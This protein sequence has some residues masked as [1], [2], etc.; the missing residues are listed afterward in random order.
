MEKKGH[1][2]Q[3]FGTSF[4]MTLVIFIVEF[5]I[6]KEALNGNI[7][8]AAAVGSHLIIS[9]ICIFLLLRGWGGRYTYLIAL[10]VGLMGPFGAGMGLVVLG[11]YVLDTF[12]VDSASNLIKELMPKMEKSKSEALYDR[13]QSGMESPEVDVEVTPL[14]DI[15]KMGTRKQKLVAIEKVLQYYHPEFI[16]ALKMAIVD[17]DNSVR[18][19]AATAISSLEDHF[20]KRFIELEADCLHLPDDPETILRFADHCFEYAKF[21]IFEEGRLKAIREIAIEKYKEYL[22]LRPEDKHIFF[23]LGS[24]YFNNGNYELA[25]ETIESLTKQPETFTQDVYLKLMDIYFHGKDF[26]KMHKLTNDN[27]TFLTSMIS[28]EGYHN[29][30]DI[31]FSW[32]SADFAVNL[33]GAGDARS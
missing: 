11:L 5:Y 16:P 3:H 25:Q 4:V 21:D 14:K 10:L 9:A 26:F 17:E 30:D 20:H 27:Y 29:F 22:N 12:F 31:L 2:L 13:I 33:E 6:W 7:S 32:G 24:L 1:Y 23:Q 15:M 18:V 28:E 19:L 8:I